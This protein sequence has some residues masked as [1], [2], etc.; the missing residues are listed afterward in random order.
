MS[1]KLA[2][3]GV[4][5]M[6][7]IVGLVF[8]GGCDDETVA[9]SQEKSVSQEDTQKTCPKTADSS[10]K[11]TCGAKADQGCPSDSKMECCAAKKKSGTCPLESSKTSSPKV[12][13]KKSETL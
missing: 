1:R 2:W 13:P 7:C 12:C 3:F 5:F 4:F 6:L 11:Q 9:S 10:R 8:M